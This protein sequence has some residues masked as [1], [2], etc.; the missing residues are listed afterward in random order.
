MKRLFAILLTLTILAT[1]ATGV[2]ANDNRD[3]NRDVNENERSSSCEWKDMDSNQ[4]DNQKHMNNDQENWKNGKAYGLW[5]KDCKDKNKDIDKENDNEKV[6]F[7]LKADSLKVVSVQFS[8]KLKASTVTGNLFDVK[9]DGVAKTFGTD[10]TIETIGKTVNI[11]FNNTLTQASKVSVSVKE[12]IKSVN[13]STVAAAT[14][15]V[16]VNDGTMPVVQKAKV[17]S[18]TTVKIAFSEPMNIVTDTFLQDYVLIDG[19]KVLGTTAINPSKTILTL[20]LNTAITKGNHVIDINS[21]LQD[22]LG[23]KTIAYQTIFSFDIE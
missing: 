2:Y 16:I 8:E 9:I 5:S 17:I 7:V 10:F 3:E 19:N 20:E 11:I 18:P 22:F 1:G 15:E 14:Q 6:T 21:G 13:C 4:Y 23:L 12:G